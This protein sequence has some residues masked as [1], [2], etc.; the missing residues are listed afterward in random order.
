MLELYSKSK[1]T[2]HRF[3]SPGVWAVQV[4]LVDSLVYVLV[5]RL[6][7]TGALAVLGVNG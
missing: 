4:A 5:R 6:S 2:Q 7:A 3:F 1:K